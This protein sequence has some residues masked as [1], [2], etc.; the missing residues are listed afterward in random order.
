MSLVQAAALGFRHESQTDWLLRNVAF[1]INAGDRIALAGPNGA[2][3]T[4][5]LRMLAGEL[6]PSE[7]AIVRRGGLRVAYVRQEVSAPAGASLEDFVLNAHLGDVRRELRALESQLDD[8][9]NAL[10]YAELLMRTPCRA[11]STPSSTSGTSVTQTGHPGPMITSSAF[12][13]VDRN[14][15]FAMACSW[16]PQTC[17]TATGRSSCATSRCSVAAIERASTGS[18]NCS[19][20][21]VTTCP[22]SHRECRWS[23]DRRHRR[24]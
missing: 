21:A 5:L 7:G 6:Q 3:K 12:G 8:E 17:I 19:G 10:R 1:E 20:V 16:L 23:S 18:R 4:S 24:R 9:A 11:S 13:N 22:R 14:P 15:N 2:G